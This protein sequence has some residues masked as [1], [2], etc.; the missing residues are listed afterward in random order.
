MNTPTLP[1]TRHVLQQADTYV[2]KNP[3]PIIVGALGLGLAIGLLS[4]PT[5]PS[6][7][8]L[9]QNNLDDTGEYLRS[10]LS[11]Y[12]KK[13][14]RAYRKAAD[15]V[16]EAVEDAVEKARDVDVH[17]YTDPVAGWWQRIWR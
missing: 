15:A 14:N 16:R 2:R 6:V 9:L 4:R 12:A 10:L 11:P 7:R 1:D 13:S 17:D 8:G 5:P 3:I